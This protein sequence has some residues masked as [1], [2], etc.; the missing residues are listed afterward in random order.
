MGNGTSYSIGGGT[1]I[2][3]AILALILIWYN[4]SANIATGYVKTICE[5]GMSI[6]DFVGLICCSPIYLLILIFFGAH[7]GIKL[8]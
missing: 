8:W 6:W 3:C 1:A 2:I 4:C 5:K 7:F